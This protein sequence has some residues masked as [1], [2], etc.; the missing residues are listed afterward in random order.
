MSDLGEQPPS[1]ATQRSQS[2]A[3]PG[4]YRLGIWSVRCLI[5]GLVLWGLYRTVE[6]ARLDLANQ[7][8]AWQSEWERLDREERQLADDDEGRA[9]RAAV[10]AERSR[11]AAS[12]V[13]WR[14][15]SPGW[16]ILAAGLYLLGGL[17]CWVFWH[18]TLRA[19]GQVPDWWSSLR[20]Y[21]IGHLGK[22]VPGKALVVVLRAGLVRSPQVDGGVAAI[23][24]FVETLTMM[25]VGA[26]WSILLLM[27][28]RGLEQNRSWLPWALGLMLLAGIPTLPPVFRRLVAFVQRRRGIAS[29][30]SPLQGLNGRLMLRGWFWMSLSWGLIGLSLWASLRALP[31]DP[32]TVWESLVDLPTVIA[33]A[34]L[35]VVLGFASLL[36][37]GVGVRE[38]VVVGLLAPLPFTGTA[39][40]LAAALL[41]RMIWLLAEVVLSSIL[42]VTPARRRVV[43]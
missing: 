35:A 32:R 42:Y 24:V 25:A 34:A 19:L 10:A 22:Y 28:S 11:L 7:Q 37:G 9:R 1:R 2:R 23:G 36:P 26:A 16:L 40:A 30:L 29:E 18:Q 39:K 5:L 31:G 14:G 27:A 15:I 13:D 6:R 38:L 17:P 8:A 12:R 43:A 20:A 3:T 21:W 4:R 41:V 33:C